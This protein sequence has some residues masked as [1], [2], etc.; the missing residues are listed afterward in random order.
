MPTYCYSRDGEVIER[1]FSMGEAPP[2]VRVGRRVFDRDY[3]AERAAT[4]PPGNWPM[5]SDA[6]GVDASQVDEARAESVR[7]G[8]PTD[9]SRDGCAI[10]TSPSHRKKYAEAIGYFDRNAGYSDPLPKRIS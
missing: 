1:F 3:T 10:F 2:R 8:V 4:R 6:V 9:F 5:E 7:L